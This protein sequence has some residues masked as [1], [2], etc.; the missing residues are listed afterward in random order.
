MLEGLCP[1]L[2]DEKR[3]ETGKNI[4]NKYELKKTKKIRKFNKNS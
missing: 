3:R 4:T 2:E 1:F